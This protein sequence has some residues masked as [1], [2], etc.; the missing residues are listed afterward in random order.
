MANNNVVL[1][2]DEVI[3]NYGEHKP[4]LDEASFSVREGS[5][6]ALMGQNGAGKTSIFSLILREQK[7]K[8]GGVFL[9]PSNATV[10]IAKQVV[11][12]EQMDLTV[13]DFFASIFKEVPYNL[14]KHIAEV[15]NAVNLKTDLTKKVREHS[16]GH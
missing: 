3:F 2:F 15:L 1:R 5:K 6:I 11:R 4:I 12:P 7:Q 14:D 8:S 10:G 16:G 9:S 13:R